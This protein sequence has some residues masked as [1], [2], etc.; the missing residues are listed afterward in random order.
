MAVIKAPTKISGVHVSINFVDG[1]AE[2]TDKWLIQWFKEHGYEVTEDSKK[3]TKG[4]EDE[5]RTESRHRKI[6]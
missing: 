3:K 1:V 6:Y 4:E 2:T 5:P